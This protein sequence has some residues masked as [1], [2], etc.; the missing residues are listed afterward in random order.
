MP[1]RTD[2]ASELARIDQRTVSRQMADAS[3]RN[4][5][6]DQIQRA[7]RIQANYS[8]LPAGASYALARGGI[9]D[10]TIYRISTAMLQNKADSTALGSNQVGDQVNATIEAKRSKKGLFGR[11]AGYSGK[12]LLSDIQGLPGGKPIISSKTQRDNPITNSVLEPAVRHVAGANPVARVLKA[13]SRNAMALMD[14]PRQALQGSYRELN[15]DISEQGVARGLGSFA[16]SGGSV[17][18]ANWLNQSDIGQSGIALATGERVDQGGGYFVGDQSGVADS[19]RTAEAAYGMVTGADG[20]QHIKSFGRD[21]AARTSMIPKVGHYVEP[22]TAGGN[23][24]SGFGDMVVALGADI[25]S[26][27]LF[28]G[29]KA[30]RDFQ[31]VGEGIDWADDVS[32]AARI[33]DQIGV[34]TN[35]GRRTTFSPRVME[36]WFSSGTGIQTADDLA[37]MDAYAVRRF[38]PKLPGEIVRGLAEADT[39]DK[40]R[41]VLRANLGRGAENLPTTRLNRYGV[42]VKTYQ[43][44]YMTKMRNRMPTGA[45]FDNGD[46]N[47]SLETF[48]RMLDM[49]NVPGEKKR[50]LFNEMAA[51][52]QTSHDNPFE[53]GAR[54]KVYFKGL[55]AGFDVAMGPTMAK[56]EGLAVPKDFDWLYGDLD[57]GTYLKNLA[58]VTDEEKAA[59]AASFERMAKVYGPDS[60]TWPEAAKEA[61]LSPTTFTKKQKDAIRQARARYEKIREDFLPAKKGR[62]GDE[63]IFQLNK[64]QADFGIWQ[65]TFEEPAAPYKFDKGPMTV[66]RR[67]GAGGIFDEP[68]PEDTVTAGGVSIHYEENKDFT[69]ITSPGIEPIYDPEIAGRSAQGVF[70]DEAAGQGVGKVYPDLSKN[71][72]IVDRLRAVIYKHADELPPEISDTLKKYVEASYKHTSEGTLEEA[73]KTLENLGPGYHNEV[74]KLLRDLGLPDQVTVY[75]GYSPI[76]YSNLEAQ[77]RDKDL[78]DP[79]KAAFFKSAI[80]LVKDGETTYAETS[81]EL[82]RAMRAGATIDPTWVEQ[83]GAINI[84]GNAP[85]GEYTNASLFRANAEGFGD[86]QEIQVPRSAIMGI[87]SPGEGEIIFRS[88]DVNTAYRPHGKAAFDTKGGPFF[89]SEFH[90]RFVP[91]PD[92]ALIHK[93][94]SKLG[95]MLNDKGHLKGTQKMHVLQEQYWKPLTIF[96]PA[97]VTKVVAETQAGGYATGFDNMLSRPFGVISAILADTKLGERLKAGKWMTGPTGEPIIQHADHLIDEDGLSKAM[98]KSSIYTSKKAA[99]YLPEKATTFQPKHKKAYYDAIA[100]QIGKMAFERH[101]PIGRMVASAMLNDVDPAIVKDQLWNMTDYRQHLQDM[102]PYREAEDGVQVMMERP[103]TDLYVDGYYQQIADYTGNDP[104]LLDA[105]VT[106]EMSVEEMSEHLAVIHKQGVELL[107]KVPGMKPQRLEEVEAERAATDYMFAIAVRAPIEKLSQN[108]LVKQAV[109]KGVEKRARFLDPAYADELLANAEKA[110]LTKS[111]MRTMKH[112]A[113]QP[114]EDGMD[115]DT[116]NELARG[117]GVAMLQKLFEDHVDKRRYIKAVELVAPFAHVWRESLGRWGQF[118]AQDPRLMHKLS[119]G[120]TEAHDP[121]TADS[122]PLG[123]FMGVPKGRGF[124]APDENGDETFIFPASPALQ[125]AFAGA[126]SQIP[127]V[128]NVDLPDTP[129][130]AKLQGVSMGFDV[131]PG[132]GLVG[133]APLSAMIPKTPEWDGVREVVLPYGDAK[134]LLDLRAQLPPH[135]RRTF[136]LEDHDTQASVWKDVMTNMVA[137]GDYDVNN[138]D[139]EI[140]EAETKRLMSDS[141][142]ASTWFTVF[143][144]LAGATAPSAPKPEWYLE[145]KTGK[146]IMLDTLQQE[147]HDA[148]KADPETAVSSIM[149]K[150]GQN[151]MVALSGKTISVALGG[152]LPPT[153]RADKWE[154]SHPGLAEDL[155][156]TYGFFAPREEGDKLDFRQYDRQMAAGER[157]SLTPEQMLQE[158]NKRVAQTI[159]Y[160][161]RNDLPANLNVKQA[162]IMRTL[163]EELAARYPGYSDKFGNEI[164]GIPNQATVSQTIDQFYKA[165]RNEQLQDHPAMGALKDYLKVRDAVRAKSAQIATSEDSWL[166]TK[167]GAALRKVMYEV[168]TKLAQTN[169]AFQPM[170]ESVLYREYQNEFESDEGITG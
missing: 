25:P 124:L 15:R 40:V 107:P 30:A 77:L 100:S 111:Q 64:A 72:D 91:T 132:M 54:T 105:I 8:W 104:K 38:G 157:F 148:Y 32:R 109:W 59:A 136:N 163:R 102:A 90:N 93:H 9:D 87:A 63:V 2:I 92:W 126:I 42:T 129:L 88:A 86:V 134:S 51:V 5:T 155:P 145:D 118:L 114:I 3:A 67:G 158:S 61:A 43:G 20:Q 41:D 69:H 112:F 167:N 56:L 24:L 76:S 103:Y 160:Q 70:R 78:L 12:D 121:N 68:I 119:Y 153:E 17:N 143:R 29:A 74:D 62:G 19:R 73:G 161:V 122:T 28:A 34:L 152:G 101:D 146:R 1:F 147:F 95:W 144:G 47:Y 84:F 16:A 36:S 110:G 123:H 6:F 96:R 18:P 65:A 75:R 49:M 58:A 125:K 133:Q 60:S 130:T 83:H 13:T 166:T 131:V 154:R 140:Q 22:G 14:A 120:Y 81:S 55:Q 27:H 71:D 44:D 139:R 117:D 150:Y 142:R 52:P 85:R 82:M 156:I 79:N 115:L 10:E 151:V 99:K 53:L 11:I 138:P 165:Q 89:L 137:T 46:S 169:K 48:D 23:I 113:E 80:P 66:R 94:T 26:N 135:I 162:A 57:E 108:N 4:V 128:G 97:M 31:A 45:L 39:P 141:R 33:R 164:V 21:L 50:S 149:E 37:E 116:L 127:G 106:G 168:G 159:Y 7:N 35:P 170:W 98:N